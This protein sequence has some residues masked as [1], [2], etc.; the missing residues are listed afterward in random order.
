MRHIVKKT[1]L[2]QT[3]I[4]CF[5][6][7][8]FQFVIKFFCILCRKLCDSFCFLCLPQKYEDNTNDSE[9]RKSCCNKKSEHIVFYK[10]Q[11]CYFICSTVID[12]KCTCKHVRR[13]SL[14]SFIQYWQKASLSTSYSKACLHCFCKWNTLE[15]L[16][17]IIYQR[18]ACSHEETV[19]FFLDDHICC[20]VKRITIYDLPFGIAECNML[21]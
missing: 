14:Y 21:F 10:V 13:H 12:S 6:Q 11:K 5:F 20:I 4:L 7:S 18:L 9:Y 3:G 17:V 2:C 16:T 8:D 15:V 1:S 19:C